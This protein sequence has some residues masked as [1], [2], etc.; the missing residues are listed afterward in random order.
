[1]KLPQPE[2][3]S[4]HHPSR[5]RRAVSP[6]ADTDALLRWHGWRIHARPRRGEARWERGGVVAGEAEALEMVRRG[7][8]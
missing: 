8:G 7:K 6:R 1:M 3:I 5:E 2:P 4:D